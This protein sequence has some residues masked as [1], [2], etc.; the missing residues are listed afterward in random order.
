VYGPQN[1]TPTSKLARAGNRQTRVSQL[2]YIRRYR[3]QLGTSVWLTGEVVLGLPTLG[4]VGFA[5]VVPC[6]CAV[7]GPRPGCRALGKYLDPVKKGSVWPS[8]PGTLG[9]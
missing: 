5:F 4:V 2:Y 7:G 1:P 8:E 9:Y 3:I 6:W